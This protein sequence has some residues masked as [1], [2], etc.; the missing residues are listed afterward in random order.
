MGRQLLPP[1]GSV[2]HF[3]VTSAILRPCW[4]ASRVL[5]LRAVRLFRSVTLYLL[6]LETLAYS[7]FQTPLRAGYMSK[8]L[9]ESKLRATPAVGVLLVMSAVTLAGCVTEVRAPPPPPRVVYVRPPPPP[10]PAPV[11]EAPAPAVDVD[12]AVQA[13]EPPP[14][15]PDY[16]QP[17]IPEE[18]YLWTPGYWGYAPAGYFWV[19]G[20]WVQP[21]RV[22]FL[23]TPGYWGFVGG[24][25]AFNVGYWGPHIGFY[26]GV[27]Y[28]FGYG[29]IGFGGGRWVGNSFAYN[30]SVTNVNVTVVHNTYNETVINN[31][32]TKVSYNGGAGGV[33][34]KATPKQLAAAQETHVPPTAMQHQHVQEAAKNPAQF[35]KTNGGKPA[36]A[37]TPKP[38]AFHAPGVVA[39]HGAV[40]PTTKPALMHAPNTAPN[41]AHPQTV[42]PNGKAPPPK[43]KAPPPPPKAPPNKKNSDNKD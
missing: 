17:P 20:T 41:T 4:V 7:A 32:T 1:G 25:Y 34:A 14:P 13:T 39:A 42:G 23:W 36:I 21:P 38:A 27:N 10:P 18:G 11:Y 40:A 15:I 6:S 33:T 22:G 29:G 30:R 24:V 2:S 9:Q 8:S 12:V 3:E 35:A 26:G 31:N 28:G 16:E 37:A 43:S 19:P 5:S